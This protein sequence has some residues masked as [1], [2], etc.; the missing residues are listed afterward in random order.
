MLETGI[1][2]GAGWTVFVQNDRWRVAGR[3]INPGLKGVND[4]FYGSSG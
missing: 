3:V 1:P 4:P 2:E